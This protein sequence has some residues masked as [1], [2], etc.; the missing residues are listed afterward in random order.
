ML[1]LQIGDRLGDNQISHFAFEM[2]KRIDDSTWCNSDKS[3]SLEIAFL[4]LNS[5]VRGLVFETLR[6]QY[7]WLYELF[8]VVVN[9]W[10]PD[11]QLVCSSR[12]MQR[13][14]PRKMNLSRRSLFGNASIV[15]ATT[16]RI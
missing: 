3:S 8:S 1:V 9:R 4:E 6:E 5:N 15:F 16:S 14:V 13:N 10:P 11:M 2:A 7:K 12:H